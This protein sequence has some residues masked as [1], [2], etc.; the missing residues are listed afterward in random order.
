M[1]MK[2]LVAPDSFKGSLGAQEA[3]LCI[4]DGLLAVDAHLEV[5]C[6]PLA[7]GGEGTLEAIAAAFPEAQWKTSLVRGP[8]GQPVK[9]QWLWLSDKKTAFLEMAQASG[10]SLVPAELRNPM[11]ASTFGTGQL[12]LDALALDPE[13]VVLTLG[14]SATVDGGVGMAE[15]LGY[16]FLDRAGERIGE[17]GAALSRLHSIDPSVKHPVFQRQSCLFSCLVDVDSPLLGPSGAAA[18]Y[19]PQKGAD[20]EQVALLE[21]GLERL[22]HVAT[23]AFGG[24]IAQQPG[25]GAAGGLSAGLAWFCGARWTSGSQK[26]LELLSFER[27]LAG[28]SLIIT[29]EGCVDGQTLN[30]KVVH[31]VSLRAR[32]HGIPVWI[33]AG[34]K[35]TGWERVADRVQCCSSIAERVPDASV[36]MQNAPEELSKLASELWRASLGGSSLPSE[37]PS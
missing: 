30:G 7:D 31:A 20:A 2:I 8:M 36:S 12:I 37:R 27:R 10:L 32:E 17:G 33:L 3:A 16:R 21:Q 23:E 9:A 19:G 18:V 24:R 11:R 15:A 4:R 6:L 1:D 25:A 28:V 34:R 29:G 13:E 26:I 14:G 22:D 5:D 35:G